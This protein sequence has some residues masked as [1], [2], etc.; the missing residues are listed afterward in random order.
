[1]LSFAA[2]M[3]LTF[4]FLLAGGGPAECLHSPSMSKYCSVLGVAPS[5]AVKLENAHQFYEDSTVF[6]YVKLCRAHAANVFA[7][8]GSRRTC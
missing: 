4:L 2:P 6:L 1:M 8:E 3:R 5:A 7:T